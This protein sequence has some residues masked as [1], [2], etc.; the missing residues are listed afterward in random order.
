MMSNVPMPLAT[1]RVGVPLMT[2]VPPLPASAVAGAMSNRMLPGTDGSLV[3]AFT[4]MVEP[5]ISPEMLP[6]VV[7]ASVGLTVRLTT[8]LTG[9]MIT[10]LFQVMLRL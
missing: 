5:E 3:T 8:L 1:S 6:W 9:T 2:A 7:M 10:V 4:T